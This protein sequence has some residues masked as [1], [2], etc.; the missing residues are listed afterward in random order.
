MLP[1]R[2]TGMPDIGALNL[3]IP[4]IPVA[5]P[6]PPPPAGRD[7]REREANLM[8][9]VRELEEEARTLRADNEKQV[10]H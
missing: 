4:T 5:P 6:A 2:P 10:C 3:N 7:G 1:P 9:R 8:R